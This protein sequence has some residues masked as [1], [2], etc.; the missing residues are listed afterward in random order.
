MW[1]ICTPRLCDRQSVEEIKG[2]QI[3]T[4]KQVA[5]VSSHSLLYVFESVPQ[6][7]SLLPK[8][9]LPFLSSCL[10][11]ASDDFLHRSIFLLHFSIGTIWTFFLLLL[12]ES[13]SHRSV[14]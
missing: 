14:M 6:I 7:S 9:E 10:H 11:A 5:L 8:I 2:N 13:S 4:H 3:K 12:F 1:A